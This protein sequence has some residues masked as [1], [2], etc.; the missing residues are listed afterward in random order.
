MAHIPILQD[1][2]K[3]LNFTKPTRELRGRLLATGATL[4]DSELRELNLFVDLLDKCL[5]MN[6]E[7]RCTPTEAL[8]HPFIYRTK[9]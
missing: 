5:N 8:K 6:P 1:V 7:K 2:V 9:G 4:P 3:I